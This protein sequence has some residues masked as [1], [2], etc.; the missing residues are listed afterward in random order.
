M[1]E[2]VLTQ[3]VPDGRRISRTEP[4]VNPGQNR[5]LYDL[6]FAEARSYVNRTEQVSSDPVPPFLRGHS[7]YFTS[8]RLGKA[9]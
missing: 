9:A 5:G 3:V 4:L 7:G 6:R 2:H 8:E 1:L